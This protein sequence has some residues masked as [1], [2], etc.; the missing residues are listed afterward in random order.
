MSKEDEEAERLRR[1][2]D[3][4]IG[5]R[6]PGQ[7]DEK[8]YKQLSVKMKKHQQYTW[9]DALRDI[10]GKWLWMFVGGV[11]GLLLWSLLAALVKAFW[12]PYAGLVIL[13]VCLLVGRVYGQAEDFKRESRSETLA[14]EIRRF[15]G[16]HR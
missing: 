13:L 6:K 8:F 3:R 12:V 9:R 11:V 15:S 1:L 2:R 7:K 5:R 10:P 4:Q 16:A 14:S